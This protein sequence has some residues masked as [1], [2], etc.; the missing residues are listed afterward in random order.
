MRGNMKLQFIHHYDLP[1]GNISVKGFWL[2]WAYCLLLTVD[3]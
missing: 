1:D 2:L 3:E